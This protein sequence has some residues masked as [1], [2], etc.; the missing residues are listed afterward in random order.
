MRL[1]QDLKA[2]DRASNQAE[3]HQDMQN[4][5]DHDLYLTQSPVT[6]AHNAPNNAST[7]S[8]H[9]NSDAIEIV[10]EP[11]RRYPRLHPPKPHANINLGHCRVT[12]WDKRAHHHDTP[13]EHQGSRHHHKP[14][15]AGLFADTKCPACLG[16]EWR[17][18]VDKGENWIVSLKW[19]PK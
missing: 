11:K 15:V 10:R 1:I 17:A 3:Q 2:N 18:G 19:S 13:T 14:R 8:P 6:N 16:K 5:K 12:S 9:V 4:A 7:G